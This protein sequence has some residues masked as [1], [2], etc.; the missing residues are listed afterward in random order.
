MNL[1]YRQLHVYIM[2]YYFQ[3]FKKLK[4]KELLTRLIIN[5]DKTMLRDFADLIK[6]C[7]KSTITRARFEESKSLLVTNNA[8]KIKKQ[9]CELLR[10]KNYVKNNEFLFVNYLHN[11]KK[12]QDEEITF[13]FARKFVYFAFFERS[14]FLIL[15]LIS[16][17]SNRTDEN[18]NRS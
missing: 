11:E 18:I 15:N 12:K 6:Q 9:R 13:F 7:S 10:L 16:R 2:R 17:V 8:N 1:S 3:M 14:L 4:E 5:T